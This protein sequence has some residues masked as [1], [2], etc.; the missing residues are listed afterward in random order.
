MRDA[1]EAE[2]S[3]EKVALLKGGILG[4]KAFKTIDTAKAFQRA[5]NELSDS[6]Y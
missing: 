6:K 1:A 2:I 5:F 3:E 4:M